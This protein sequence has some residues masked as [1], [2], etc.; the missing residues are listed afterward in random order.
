MACSAWPTTPVFSEVLAGPAEDSLRYAFQS[1]K[2]GHLRIQLERGAE[3]AESVA[4]GSKRYLCR[5]GEWRLLDLGAY[6]AVLD[7][8]RAGDRQMS[9]R[10]TLSYR[11]SRRSEEAPSRC[12]PLAAMTRSSTRSP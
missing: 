11:R 7:D 10:Q 2:P 8:A 4:L 1:D 6:Q 12:P 5:Q 9:Y 3:V